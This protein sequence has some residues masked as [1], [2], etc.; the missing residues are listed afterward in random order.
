[1]PYF[2]KILWR[3]SPI[4][5]AWKLSFAEP[6]HFLICEFSFA[7]C[8]TSAD[9]A[10][11]IPHQT[12]ERPGATWRIPRREMWCPSDQTTYDSWVGSRNQGPINDQKPGLLQPGPSCDLW[13][14]S[15]GALFVS[16]SARKH[17][18]S[19]PWRWS[20]SRPCVRPP[21][22]GT[23]RPAHWRIG[24]GFRRTLD[25]LQS[26]RISSGYDQLE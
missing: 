1:M 25:D 21:R 18:S 23:W 14:S 12:T 22:S 16:F 9:F 20:A 26:Y 5:P 11:W 2:S 13:S 6:P 17:A 10:T 7:A 19:S 8:T 3:K 4:N 15:S 24:A